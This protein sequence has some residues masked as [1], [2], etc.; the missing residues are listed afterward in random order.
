MNLH[1]LSLWLFRFSL[2]SF[3]LAWVLPIFPSKE[4]F[5]IPGAWAFLVSPFV[6]LGYWVAFL[7]NGFELSTLLMAVLLTVVTAMNCVFALAPFLREGFAERPMLI[8]LSA[9]ISAL[10]AAMI[11]HLPPGSEELL[12]VWSPVEL[13]WIASFVLMS[14]SGVAGCFAGVPEIT[15]CQSL[16]QDDRS[17]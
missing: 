6:T 9:G 5:L 10:A 11:C 2:V 15:S 3:A 12:P 13:A 4:G 1:G 17:S 7:F 14:A 8:S 16:T